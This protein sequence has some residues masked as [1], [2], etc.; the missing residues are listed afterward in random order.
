MMKNWK[1]NTLMNRSAWLLL[2]LV[3]PTCLYAAE[4]AG[5]PPG[6]QPVP[7]GAPTAKDIDEPQ[8]TIRNQGTQRIEEYRLHGKLYMIKI[9]PGK[10]KKPYYLVDNVGDG[11]FVRYD[12]PA[13]PIAVPMWV[14]KTF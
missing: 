2:A 10:G 13:A 5:P 3:S 1:R 7:D 11:K 8:I 12:G 14:I 4:N 9:T 6:S